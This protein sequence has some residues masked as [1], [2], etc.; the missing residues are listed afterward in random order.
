MKIHFVIF[1]L[2]AISIF[3]SCEKNDTVL[4]PVSYPFALPKAGVYNYS[5]FDSLGIHIVQGKISFY[6]ADSIRI[7][8]NWNLTAVGNPG[9]IGPQIGNVYRKECQEKKVFPAR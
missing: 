4:S 1:L 9:A 3:L 7:R 2:L 8:G 6:Y 5:G